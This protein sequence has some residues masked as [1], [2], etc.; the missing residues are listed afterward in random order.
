MINFKTLIYS[1]IIINSLFN[2]V[3]GSNVNAQSFKGR[4]EPVHEAVLSSSVDGK[5]KSILFQEGQWVKKGDPVVHLNNKEQE[6]EVKLRYII[7]KNKTAIEAAQSEEQSIQSLFESSNRLFENNRSVSKEELIRL[8]M[9]Y[10]QAR[11]KRLELEHREEEEQIQYELAKEHLEKRCL[12]APIKGIITDI[13]IH[14]GERCKPNESLIKI[15]DPTECYFVC[16]MEE[17]Y[18]Q[19]LKTG[20]QVML[21]IQ[22]GQKQIMT[23]GQ[24]VFVSP[25]VDSAS[26]FMKI[27][28]KFDNKELRFRPGVSGN[29]IIKSE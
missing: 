17:Q 19:V 24:V 2:S 7:W 26:G 9:R 5:I 16:N 12:N 21:E 15:V 13:Y 3:N 23:Y 18:G 25:I 8:K 14:A 29:L 10:D 22:T 28:A 4:T 11:F 1:Y 20:H 27:K 6:L